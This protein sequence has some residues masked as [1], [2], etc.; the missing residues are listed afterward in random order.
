MHDP[1]RKNWR[2]MC[3]T[4]RPALQQLQLIAPSI[5]AIVPIGQMVPNPGRWSPGL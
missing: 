4:E 5:R 1:S 3:S 2:Y